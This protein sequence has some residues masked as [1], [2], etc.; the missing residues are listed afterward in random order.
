MSKL[1]AHNLHGN[2]ARIGRNFRREAVNYEQGRSFGDQFVWQLETKAERRPRHS[3]CTI[4]ERQGRLVQSVRQP[5]NG[6]KTNRGAMRTS[7]DL[8]GSEASS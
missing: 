4:P 8:F 6:R 2:G 3:S 7:V 5:K 1:P